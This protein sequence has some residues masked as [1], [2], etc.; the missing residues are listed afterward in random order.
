M[1]RPKLQNYLISHRKRCGLTQ[2]E[3]AFLVGCK[4]S[5]RISHYEHNTRQPS[6]ATAL[7]F[8][9]VCRVPTRQL[10]AGLYSRIEKE[11]ADRSRHLAQRW[12]SKHRNHGGPVSFNK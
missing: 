9:V 2:A 12:Y 11:V 7:A 1:T 5:S 4:S 3:V 8:E 6:L 10:F